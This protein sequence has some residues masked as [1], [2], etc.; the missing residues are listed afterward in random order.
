[1]I[2]TKSVFLMKYGVLSCTRAEGSI[3][4]D[5]VGGDE[6]Y[7][8]MPVNVQRIHSFTNL[9]ASE[10]PVEFYL[11]SDASAIIE[12]TKKVSAICLPMLFFVRLLCIMCMKSVC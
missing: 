6:P 9:T 10:E 5:N 8:P 2:N 3:I 7:I 4:G 1:M 12:H 11:A